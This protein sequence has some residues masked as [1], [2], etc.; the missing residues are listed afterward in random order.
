M[1]LLKN[2]VP[3]GAGGSMSN[4]NSVLI[5]G[6]L[7]NNPESKEMSGCKSA[8]CFFKISSCHRTQTSMTDIILE[9]KTDNMLADKCGRD[10]KKD[11]MVRVVGRLSCVDNNII[12]QAEHIE[13]K[14]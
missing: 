6:I 12:I 1:D 10:L 2:I 3:S 9:I 11:M 14:P 7:I 5:E 13:I 8:S 4:L